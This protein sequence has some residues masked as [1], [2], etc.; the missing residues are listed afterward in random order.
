MSGVWL[1]GPAL[2]TLHKTVLKSQ[3]WRKEEAPKRGI[4][5]ERPKV[6]V[7]VTQEPQLRLSIKPFCKEA[8]ADL[9]SAS[10]VVSECSLFVRFQSQTQNSNE[11]LLAQL[12]GEM[13]L[14][15]SIQSRQSEAISQLPPLNSV[16]RSPLCHFPHANKENF[17]I[18]FK[19]LI[20][21]NCVL[22]ANLHL[23]FIFLLGGDGA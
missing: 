6:T 5:E 9:P 19:Q 13:P 14:A 4:K 8:L 12:A 20:F 21:L 10:F 18:K 23:N 2:P 17:T 22:Q 11:G 1:S 3:H 16:N 7:K 15:G